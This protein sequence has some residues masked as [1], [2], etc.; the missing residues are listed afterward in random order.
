M[1]DCHTFA[2]GL[3]SQLAAPRLH[4]QKYSKVEFHKPAVSYLLL[5]CFYFLHHGHSQALKAQC[6]PIQNRVHKLLKHRQAWL[7]TQLVE[8]EG[9]W[10]GKEQLLIGC[11]CLQ[12]DHKDGSVCDTSSRV[13]WPTNVPVSSSITASHQVAII[14]DTEK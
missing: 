9:I 7:P 1:G 8:L 13:P 11:S 10:G 14:G 6:L 5:L 2:S 12:V 3:L 4:I